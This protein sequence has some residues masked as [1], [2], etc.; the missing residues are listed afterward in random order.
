[1]QSTRTRNPV[2]FLSQDAKGQNHLEFPG[3]FS[4]NDPR[5]KSYLSLMQIIGELL[6]GHLYWDVVHKTAYTQILS[7]DLAYTD[8]LWPVYRNYTGLSPDLE[9]PNLVWL[10]FKDTLEELFRNMTLSLLSISS[11]H[12]NLTEMISVSVTYTYNAYAYSP[13]RLWAPYGAAIMA[14]LV[15]VAVGFFNL[16]SSG[17]SYSNKFSTIVRVSHDRAIDIAIRDE[18]RYGQDPLPKYIGKAKLFVRGLK[19]RETE[20]P[21]SSVQASGLPE[22]AAEGLMTGR[23]TLGIAEDHSDQ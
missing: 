4:L 20:S 16:I 15:A 6:V 7:T 12:A 1:M 2:R 21:R 11:V 9:P 3:A 18:D 8:A 17:A 5:V 13:Q 10:P 22:P 23:S 19:D 14:T